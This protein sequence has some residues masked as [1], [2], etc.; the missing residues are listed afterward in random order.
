[1]PLFPWGDSDPTCEVANHGGMACVGDTTPVGAYPQGMS[2]FG[3]MDLSG[4]VWEWV[5]DCWHPDYEE[6]PTDGAAW[7]EPYG[8]C[9][10]NRRVIRGGSYDYGADAVRLSE[11]LENNP[12]F[13]S[14]SVGFR[15][16][17]GL[18]D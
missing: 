8:I 17:R 11:R 18:D 13:G 6:A 9:E 2:R 14:A 10:T 3:V 5:Q 12:K 1:M 4:N 16:C 15:C 7:V